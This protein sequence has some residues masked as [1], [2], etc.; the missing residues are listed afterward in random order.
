MVDLIC[1]S[2]NGTFLSLSLNDL[3]LNGN[4]DCYL[5]LYYITQLLMMLR[6]GARR[7]ELYCIFGKV[8]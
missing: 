5:H 6:V 7:S 1:G 8:Q 3:R 4:V 2:I